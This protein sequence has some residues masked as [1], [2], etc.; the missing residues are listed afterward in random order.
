MID[1]KML[2]GKLL[3]VEDDSDVRNILTEAFEEEGYIVM[4]AR[5]GNQR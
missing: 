5:R 2:P 3:I 1:E 4:G